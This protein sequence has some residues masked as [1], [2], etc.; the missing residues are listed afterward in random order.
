MVSA[1]PLQLH[2][3]LRCHNNALS[4]VLCKQH[5]SL[6]L[7]FVIKSGETPSGEGHVGKPSHGAGVPRNI[8]LELRGCVWLNLLISKSS[9]SEYPLIT[10]QV[11]NYEAT[12]VCDCNI[13]SVSALLV[14]FSFK[15]S[16]F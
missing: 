10:P 1:Q 4:L 6:L 11:C 16:V 15:E 12:F 7:A 14:P 8:S 2:V 13:P 3:A 5:I 9:R